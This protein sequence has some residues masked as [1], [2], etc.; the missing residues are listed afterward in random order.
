MKS[1]VSDRTIALRYSRRG[2]L[3]Q[4]YTTRFFAAAECATGV[5]A[6]SLLLSDAVD[7]FESISSS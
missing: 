6:L 4:A 1:K 5:P 2:G 3:V 7:R